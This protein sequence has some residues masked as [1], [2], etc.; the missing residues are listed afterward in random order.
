MMAGTQGAKVE[1]T[2]LPFGH[3]ALVG[4]RTRSAMYEK[5]E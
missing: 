5:T 3:L 2:W 1:G 4:K